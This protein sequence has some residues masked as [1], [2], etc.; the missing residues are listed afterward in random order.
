M[1]RLPVLLS[2][3]VALFVI[4]PRPLV[5]HH[6][7]AAEFDPNRPFAVTGVVTKVEWMN[8]HASFFIDVADGTDGRVQTWAMEMSSPNTLQRAGWT[9]NSIKVGDVVTVEGS[10]ARD[11]SRTGNARAVTLADTGQRLFTASSQ[12]R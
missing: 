3:V 4:C 1:Q 10:F 9:R 11:G 5:G 6:S 7:F 8:P 2:G 12:S